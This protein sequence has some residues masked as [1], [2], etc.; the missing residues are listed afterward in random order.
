[1]RYKVYLSDASNY[2]L[3]TTV[4][5]EV[6]GDDSAGIGTGFFFD[7]RE[8]GE[9]TGS[10][11]LVTNKHVV[12]GAARATIH[13]HRAR[14]GSDGKGQFVENIGP[15]VPV[16]IP[17]VPAIFFGHS[18]PAVDLCAA[19]WSAIEK[20]VNDPSIFYEC[21]HSSW[22]MSDETLSRM[23]STHPIQMVGYPYGLADEYNN[24]P[25]I[26]HGFTSL[27]PSIDFEARHETVIDIATDPGSSGSPVFVLDNAYFASMP[28]FVAIP[29]A[30]PI[31][32]PTGRIVRRPIPLHMSEGGTGHDTLHFGYA[33]KSAALLELARQITGKT[34]YPREHYLNWPP[35]G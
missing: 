8:P 9:R 14:R 7:C 32:G 16:S 22:I 23:R 4:R 26:R 30:G 33:I 28:C 18:D 25:L 27:Q 10:I 31:V 15:P 17:D 13:L 6:E 20:Y 2:L 19:P 11:L 21:V 29:Y 24:F 3:F 34:V 35:G 1:M 5:I 12:E